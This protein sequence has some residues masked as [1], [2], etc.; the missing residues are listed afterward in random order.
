M[1]PTEQQQAIVAPGG[2]VYWLDGQLVLVPYGVHWFQHP[3][4]PQQ[5]WTRWPKWRRDPRKDWRI[6]KPRPAPDADCWGLV[7][8]ELSSLTRSR[9]VFQPSKAHRVM[10]VLYASQESRY[11]WR[12]RQAGKIYDERHRP[13]LPAPEPE[14][15]ATT[16]TPNRNVPADEPPPTSPPR[17]EEVVPEPREP[18]AVEDATADGSGSDA[19]PAVAVPPRPSHPPRIVPAQP[20]PVAGRWHKVLRMFRGRRSR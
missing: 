7:P 16:P 17:V 14:K 12:N 15:A 19:P 3:V 13:P 2:N 10:D 11:R 6:S 9:A 20:V 18:A 8:I 1:A 5:D 4:R